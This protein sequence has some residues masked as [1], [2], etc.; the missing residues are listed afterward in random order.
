MRQRSRGR[1]ALAGMAAMCAVV[2]LPG[3]VARAA[4]EP[5]AYTFDSGAERVRGAVTSSETESLKPGSVYRDTIK[6]DG[7]LYYRVDLDAETNAYVS[8]VVVPRQGAEAEYGDGVKVV[9]EDGSSTQCSSENAQF[10]SAAYTRPIAAYAHRTIEPDSS[11]CQERGAYYV[12]VE[13]TTKAP[14]AA[15]DWDLEIRYDTEP[16]LKAAGPTEAPEDWPSASPAPPAGGPQKRLGGTSY[17]DAM[18]LG[19]GEW[20]DDIKPGQTRFYRVPVDWGQQLFVQADL[21][22]SAAGDE[23]IGNAF[24]LSLDN[25]ARGH[26]DQNT[27]SYQGKQTSM[28]LDPLP[29]VAYRNRYASDS[30]VSAVRFAGWYYLSASISPEVAEE[31]GDTA[32]PL[33]LRVNVTGSANAGPGY[34]GDAGVFAV[35]DDDQEA[36]ADG[37]SGPGAARSDTMKV[38]ATAGIGAGTV[39]VLG[40]GVWTL[41]ARRAA[42]RTGGAGGTASAQYGPPSGGPHG[43]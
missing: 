38:V 4:G 2:A 23:Y 25:P 41:L 6:K 36:A 14:S 5:S 19:T 21:G 7:K 15:D 29:P 30:T 40:L 39:L 37:Q 3:Q 17:S 16:G 42:G 22:S 10:E 24:V 34:D 13:R 8:V 43:W 18:S 35:T 32:V 9:L 12:V 26:V 31:Y 33:T 20:R 1:V 27:L 11:T 28:A